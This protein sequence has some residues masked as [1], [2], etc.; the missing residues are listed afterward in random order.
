M[1][2]YLAEFIGSFILVF[3]G[4]GSVIVN[5]VTGGLVSHV[6]YNFV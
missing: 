3:M 6:S 4:T 1:G 2:V 5:D